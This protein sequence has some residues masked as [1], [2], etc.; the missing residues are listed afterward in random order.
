MQRGSSETT[1]EQEAC[2]RSM[3][4]DGARRDD[5]AAAVGMT[6]DSFATAQKR[7]A[8]PVRPRSIGGAARGIDPT[9]AEIRQ[10]TA[11]IRSR[12]TDA[13]HL[14]RAGMID[15]KTGEAHERGYR[16]IPIRELDWSGLE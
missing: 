6:R 10:A 13:D 9:E 8:L 14:H 7:L 4:A 2:I 15:P 1:P 5:I 11:E 3:W 12:W 16:I